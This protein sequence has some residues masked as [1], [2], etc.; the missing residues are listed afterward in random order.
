MN[1]LLVGMIAILY[2]GLVFSAQGTEEFEIGA[3]LI[4]P[5]RSNVPA[6][7]QA[8]DNRLTFMDSKLFDAKLAKELDSGAD[9]VNV[10]ITG[11]ISLNS[12]PPRM[13]KWIVRCAETGTVEFL[14]IEQVPQARF[15]LFALISMAFSAMP[16]LKTM[17]EDLMYDKIG[18]YDTKIYYKRD[19]SG[20]SLI[21]RMVMTKRKS[22]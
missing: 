2:A 3:D 15:F 5:I 8:A 20:E 12:I 14:P 16:F 9:T 21:D 19:E 4:Q 10:M 11:R 13:D 6:P 7:R 17:R 22:K 18:G 1:K